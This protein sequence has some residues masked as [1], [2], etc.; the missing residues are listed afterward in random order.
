MAAARLG[1]VLVNAGPWLAVPP[2]GYGGIE[3]VLATLIPELRARGVRVALATVGES[4]IAVDRTVAV[5][6]RGQFEQLGGPYNRVVGIAHAHMHGVL[7]ELRRAADVDLV[8]DHLEVVGPSMLAALER[9]PP[10]LQTLHWSLSKHAG[11]YGTFDG[12]GRIF[13]NALSRRQ[14]AEAPAALRRQVLARIPLATPA[15]APDA[16]HERDR[17]GYVALLGRL[18]WEKGADIAARTCRRCGRELRMAG[19]V[20]GALTAHDLTMRMAEPAWRAR[21]DAA[22][23]LERV[24][25]LEDERVRWIG[26]LDA[27]ATRRFLSGARALL[28]PLR[29]EEPGATA[30]IEALACGTPVVAMRRGALPEV[31]EHGVT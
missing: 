10:T 7:A 5:F 16:A 4:T 9:P 20:A 26:T 1:T 30:A 24:R 23:Y 25:P 17:G 6:E 27:D 8:H 28:C 2:R 22:F 13:F 18:C 11:F 14:L 19:P 12:R 3:N 29:W 21:A 31:V 15:V